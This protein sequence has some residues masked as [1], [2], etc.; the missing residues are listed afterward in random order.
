M[1]ILS[2]LSQIKQ[3]NQ[4]PVLSNFITAVNYGSLGFCVI[5]VLLVHN[6]E[7]LGYNYGHIAVIRDIWPCGL[8]IQLVFS[9]NYGDSKRKFF[10]L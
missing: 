8:R 10:L 7:H 2:T 4:E 1:H 9:V 5:N 3:I 6:Y